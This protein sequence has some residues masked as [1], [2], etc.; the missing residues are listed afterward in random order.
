MAPLFELPNPKASTFSVQQREIL[1][2]ILTLALVCI[3][4]F[5]IRLFSVLRY[6]SII[7]EFDPV[8]LHHPCD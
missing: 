2:R 3:V 5:S 1:L 6:E 8:R 4:S 7:H